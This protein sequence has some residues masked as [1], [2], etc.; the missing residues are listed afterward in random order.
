MSKILDYL[1][2]GD[3]ST[4]KNLKELQ[5][6]GITHVLNMAKEIPD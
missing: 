2:V 5:E 6:L 3:A 4:A 1:Y